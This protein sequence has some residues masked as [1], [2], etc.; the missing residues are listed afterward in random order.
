MFKIWMVRSL[1]LF[2]VIVAAPQ[3]HA[4]CYFTPHDQFTQNARIDLTFPM[5]TNTANTISVPPDTAVG[6]VIYRQRINITTM[7]PAW[8]VTCDASKVFFYDY[9]YLTTPRAEATTSTPTNRIYQTDLPG[10][11]VR[12]TRGSSATGVI[13]VQ[14]SVGVSIATTIFSRLPSHQKTGSDLW[15]NLVKTG[16]ITPGTVNAS[17]LPSIKISVGQK[18]AD[19]V[20][21]F[22]LKVSGAVTITTPT[23]NV[24]PVSQ[25]QVI[26]MGLYQAS[27]FTGKYSATDW[28]KIDIK[29]NC[30]NRFHGRM[31]P[32]PGN[33]YASTYTGA[34]T[35]TKALNQNIWDAT[36]TEVH[37]V[38]DATRGI[39]KLAAESGAATGVG[40]QLSSAQNETSVIKFTGSSSSYEIFTGGI[41]QS[42]NSS[43]IT[44]S[45]YARYIQT[46]NTITPGKANSSII[47]NMIYK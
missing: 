40:I 11:G 6:T 39:I 13:P 30:P 18:P 7:S 44:V 42:A 27:E 15:L 46:E 37:G 31:L 26:Q 10:I 8:E 29:I 9:A 35:T 2:T 21:L 36:F 41:S 20:G 47:Y 33:N 19:W 4:A 5:M 45:L 23:C 3:I 22:T 43:A 16:D 28:K 24:L 1:M 14:A 12:F 32:T 17:S 34:T 38:A 25:S